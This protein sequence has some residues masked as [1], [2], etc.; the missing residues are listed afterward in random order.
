MSDGIQCQY[1]GE[2]SVD[3]FLEFSDS[4]PDRGIISG[5]LFGIG[6]ANTK[7]HGLQHRAQE[8][9][10]NRNKKKQDKKCVHKG[11]L[12]QVY[13]RYMCNGGRKA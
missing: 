10:N 4:L 12:W 6:R 11:V 1:G 3:I 9:R 5:E 2:G 13:N 7:Q 8:R